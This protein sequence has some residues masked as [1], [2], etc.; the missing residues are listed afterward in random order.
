MC[1]E[2]KISPL[3]DIFFTACQIL[4]CIH[5]LLGNWTDY[6]SVT[7]W[8]FHSTFQLSILTNSFS[9]NTCGY[10]HDLGFTQVDIWRHSRRFYS[11]TLWPGSTWCHSL[12]SNS[13]RGSPHSELQLEQ[14]TFTTLKGIVNWSSY[15]MMLVWC[16]VCL[17]MWG[18]QKNRVLSA[19]EGRLVNMSPFS[20]EI[21]HIIPALWQYCTA[22]VHCEIVS[23]ST[24]N[25]FCSYVIDYYEPFRTL[26]HSI[27]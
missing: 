14:R 16:Q 23:T 26:L 8:Q 5:T 12:C 18:E 7:C 11:T 17:K 24:L 15:K 9:T 19:A 1:T 27:P 2:R 22:S 13:W 20:T 25:S 21:L 10:V 3:G 4:H 6:Y